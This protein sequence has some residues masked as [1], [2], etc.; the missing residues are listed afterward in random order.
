LLAFSYGRG[1]IERIWAEQGTIRHRAE[2]VMKRKSSTASSKRKTADPTAVRAATE[3]LRE[4]RRAAAA[5]GSEEAVR[6]AQ[7]ALRDAMRNWD[8]YLPHRPFL[9]AI[10][11]APADPRPVL[12][13]ADWLEEHND[14]LANAA[15][16]GIAAKAGVLPRPQG[17]CWVM[18]ARAATRV[19]EQV[20]P[21]TPETTCGCAS[22][23]WIALA[24]HK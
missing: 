9:D 12:A 14:G 17:R 4:A 2:F 15:A 21:A 22:A 1:N 5:G 18:P 10:D 16:V 24:E 19:G 6:A 7:E 20:L 11:A 3:A 8:P 13:W 23:A